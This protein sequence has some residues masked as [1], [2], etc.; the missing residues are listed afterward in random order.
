MSDRPAGAARRRLPIAGYALVF[1][2][3][4]VVHIWVGTGIHPA[5][6][7]RPLIVTLVATIILVAALTALSRSRDLGALATTAV[8]LWLIAAVS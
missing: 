8:A 7:V 5:S 6:M 1:P 2:V 4:M 3:A